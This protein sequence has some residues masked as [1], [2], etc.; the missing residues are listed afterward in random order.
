M[1]K[2]Q[3]IYQNELRNKLYKIQRDWILY[4]I[5]LASLIYKFSITP[6]NFVISC[7]ESEKKRSHIR[8][9][10]L[11]REISCSKWQSN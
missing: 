3:L 11:A 4:N 9:M 2:K 10:N 7:Q 1:I 6:E 5:A 8:L